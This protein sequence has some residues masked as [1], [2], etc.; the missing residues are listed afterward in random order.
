MNCSGDLKIVSDYTSLS[1]TEVWELEIFDYWGYLHDC[2][3]WNC[4]K[5]EEGR[6]Y[7]ASAY[8]HS[9]TEPDRTKLR[10][11]CGGADNGKQ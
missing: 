9:R 4:G 10:A 1:F 8:N 2:V 3:V 6:A 5:T 11:R 7:L